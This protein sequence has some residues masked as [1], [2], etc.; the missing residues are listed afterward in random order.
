[1]LVWLTVQERGTASG[2]YLMPHLVGPVSGHGMVTA[3]MQ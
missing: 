1:M 2:V 3:C